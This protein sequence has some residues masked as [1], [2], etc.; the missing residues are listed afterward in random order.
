MPT[1]DESLVTEKVGVLWDIKINNTHQLQWFPCTV[2]R[3]Y[4]HGRKTR[5]RVVNFEITF[6]DGDYDFDLSSKYWT[7]NE[8]LDIGTTK[9]AEITAGMWVHLI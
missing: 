3:H 1:L 2:K 6:E 7:N 8:L 4:A 5:N 9:G